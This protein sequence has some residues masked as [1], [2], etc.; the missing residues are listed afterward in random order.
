MIATVVFFT[1][2]GVFKGVLVGV[3]G[4][5]VMHERARQVFVRAGAWLEV[6]EFVSSKGGGA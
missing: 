3:V 5:A 2:E 6:V 4:A 1:K